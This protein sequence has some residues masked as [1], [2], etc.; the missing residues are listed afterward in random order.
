MNRRNLEVVAVI[1][2][3]EV[4]VEASDM[5]SA[6]LSL[7]HN[8]LKLLTARRD[9][10]LMKEAVRSK[11]LAVARYAR[12][13]TLID[14]EEMLLS[15][16]VVVKTPAGMSTSDVYICS[17]VEEAEMAL[18]SIVSKIGPD[19]RRVNEAL[20]EEFIHG[21]EFAVNLMAFQSQPKIK[22]MIFT[23]NSHSYV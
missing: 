20:L 18:Q 17:N 9:K 10:G 2:L 16:P 8:P 14:L 1:P 7:P 22:A 4:A 13:K 21:T 5:I 12:V 3:S 15:Y 11:G 6:A 19:G 23:P